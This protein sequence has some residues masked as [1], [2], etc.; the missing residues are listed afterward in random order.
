MNNYREEIDNKMKTTVE[1]QS[2][3]QLILDKL[4]VLLNPANASLK[5]KEKEFEEK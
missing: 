5:A 1:Q 4:P 2:R 3:N